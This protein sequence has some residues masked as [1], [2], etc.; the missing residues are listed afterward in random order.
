MFEGRDRETPG[1]LFAERW[2]IFRSGVGR[3]A[4]GLKSEGTK[5]KSK[6][7]IRKRIRS[8]IKIK[9]RTEPGVANRMW[10]HCIYFT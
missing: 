8:K 7:T 4:R 9:M 6:I 2:S 1:R 10:R 3:V 5:S